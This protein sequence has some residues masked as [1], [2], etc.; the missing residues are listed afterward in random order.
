M[1]ETDLHQISPLDAPV[2]EKRLVNRVLEVW[3]QARGDDP[4]PLVGSLPIA[5]FGA[6]AER[7]FI[8]D[9][10]HAKG[11]CFSYIGAAVRA[12]AWRGEEEALVAACPEDSV[13]GLVSRQWREVAD[14]GVPITRG[15]SG[16][17]DGGPVLYRGI[18]MP[19]ANTS[20]QIVA[21]IGAANWRAVKESDDAART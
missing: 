11:P 19:L 20:G 5:E 14:R 2:R 16:I 9:L 18:L 17:N 13:L 3:R 21:I 12:A 1:A 4:M 10:L 8:I 15:D 7:I 6:D